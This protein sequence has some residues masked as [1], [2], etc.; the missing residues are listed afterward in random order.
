M[1]PPKRYSLFRFRVFVLINGILFHLFSDFCLFHFPKLL[2]SYLPSFLY[3]LLAKSFKIILFLDPNIR[4][5]N[6]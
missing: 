1:S 6:C 3:A 5:N 4:P 2:P